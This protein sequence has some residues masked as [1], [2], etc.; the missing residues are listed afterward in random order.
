ML[1][2]RAC[3]RDETTTH[4]G[5]RAD[6]VAVALM[7]TL[8]KR[9]REETQDLHTIAER[10][11]I[12][13]PLLRGTLA[14][15][16]YALLLRNLFD[17]YGALESGMTA[18]ERDPVLAPFAHPGLRRVSSLRRDLDA[19]GGAAWPTLGVT[20][21]TQRYVG[22]LV[23]LADREP[24]LLLAHAYVRYLGDLSGGQH[25]AR[26][27]RRVLAP[28]FENAVEFYDFPDLGDLDAFKVGVREG[29]DA[30]LLSDDV[31]T[32]LVAEA[33]RGF[34]MHATL[35][36]ELVESLPDGPASAG[37]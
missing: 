23:D 17:I 22:R 5:V 12:M 10:S 28:R 19:I 3:L 31:V 30:L 20:A 2:R 14:A 27:V 13:R 29:M 6:H 21:T 36:N 25:I 24:R 1:P 18:H 7:A 11:G 4:S 34:E 9:L 15:S 33:R 8:S 32:E 16:E 35:F 26:I 37:G